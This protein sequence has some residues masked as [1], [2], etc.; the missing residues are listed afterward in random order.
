MAAI[1]GICQ[2]AKVLGAPGPGYEPHE[3][4]WSIDVEVDDATREY[5]TGLG[6]ADK[7]RSKDGREDFIPFKRNELKKDGTPSK[8]IAVVD[9]NRQPWDE[10]KLI[11]NGS[12]VAVQFTVDPWEYGRK[13]GIRLGLIKIMV[14]DHV[15]YGE[16]E[17]SEFTDTDGFDDDEIPFDE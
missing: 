13:S 5:L 9:R 16:D 4:E 10:T 1:S 15:P 14:L 12:R 6:V 17:F 7:I 2:W 8:P 3:K 11:G